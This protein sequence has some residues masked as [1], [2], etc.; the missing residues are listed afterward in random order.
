ML[1]TTPE[2]ERLERD[3]LR[4]RTLDGDYASALEVFSA[5]WRHAAALNPAPSDDWKADLAPDLAVARAINGLP[6]LP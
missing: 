6:P 5:M 4:A 1:R 3:D 2:L